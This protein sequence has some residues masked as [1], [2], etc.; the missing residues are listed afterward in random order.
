MTSI[1][2]IPRPR[3][4]IRRALTVGAAIAAIGAFAV[5]HAAAADNTLVSSSPAAGSTV[6]VSPQ[7]L[8]LTFANAIGGTNTVEVVCNGSPISVGTPQVGLDSL[9]LTVL[10]PN[11]LPK[12]QCVVSWL[13]STPDGVGAGSSTFDFTIANDPVPTLAPAV[14]TAA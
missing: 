10:V 7:S 11:P 9:S 1:K 5:P 6:D 13:V 4:V 2:R 12:G 8:S 14:T 3:R